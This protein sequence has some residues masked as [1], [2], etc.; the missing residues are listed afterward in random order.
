M[1]SIEEGPGCTN[2]CGLQEGSMT[3]WLQSKI[4]LSFSGMTK[5]KEVASCKRV[6]SMWNILQR[7]GQ[8]ECSKTQFSWRESEGQN[9]GLT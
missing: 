1:R 9:T 2:Y 7:Q 5:I 4:Y 6:I 8:K 3:V